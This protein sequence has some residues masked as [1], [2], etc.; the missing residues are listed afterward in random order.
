MTTT[1]PAV[2]Y[3]DRDVFSITLAESSSAIVAR[4]ILFIKIISSDGFNPKNSEDLEY[5]WSVWFNMEWST[6]IV[7]RFLKDVYELSDAGL[8]SFVEVPESDD[9]DL[10][11][12]IWRM[13]I[14]VTSN[15]DFTMRE[16]IRKE[17][18]L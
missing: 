2:S 11:K 1:L 6:K 10:L 4:N 15:I 16:R 17:R 9:I 18:Y 14:S 7:Q 3:S 8:P 13:W 5:V 12:S